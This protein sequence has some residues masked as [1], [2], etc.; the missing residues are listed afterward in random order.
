MLKWFCGIFG[1][2]FHF[3]RIESKIRISAE[4]APYVKKRRI[5]H[6]YT[7]TDQD[8]G[9]IIIHIKTSGWF[10]LKRWVLSF[11]KDAEVLAPEDLRREIA[12]EIHQLIDHYQ[13]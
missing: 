5:G 9:S 6:D 2:T 13:K 11:G 4:Q 7:I 12:N 8:D 10:D 1:H 3:F